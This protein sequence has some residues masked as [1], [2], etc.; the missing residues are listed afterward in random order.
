MEG[1]RDKPSTP[2]QL[3]TAYGTY[4]TQSAFT[5]APVSK[6]E[7]VLAN[8]LIHSY[9]HIADSLILYCTLILQYMQASATW[10]SFGGPV[11]YSISSCLYPHQASHQVPPPGQGNTEQKRKATLIA[12]GLVCFFLLLYLSQAFCA[13]AMLIIA[14]VLHLG[15]SGIPKKVLLISHISLCLEIIDVYPISR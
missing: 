11:L 2:S 7:K 5:A 3:V 12:K 6:E 13:E 14:S 15:R 4:A 9:I 10:L 8:S 1:E